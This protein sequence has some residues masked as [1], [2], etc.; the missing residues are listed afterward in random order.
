VSNAFFEFFGAMEKRGNTN[1]TQR[2]GEIEMKKLPLFMIGLMACLAIGI[3]TAQGQ[4][5]SLEDLGVV[6]GMDVSLPAALNFYG[7]VAG[8]AYKK[9]ETCA[10]Y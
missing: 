5:Y 4:Q 3:S 6:K 8:T 2:K 9:G 10:F 1:S 7:H